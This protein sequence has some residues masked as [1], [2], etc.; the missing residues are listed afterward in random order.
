MDVRKRLILQFILQLVFVGAVLIGLMVGMI[1]YLADQMTEMEM[2]REFAK[3]GLPK[4]VESMEMKEGTFQFDENL[5]DRVKQS[6]GWLQTLDEEGQV[7][8]SHFT[9]ANVPDRYNPGELVDYWMGKKP[10]P[11]SLYIWIQVKGGTTYTLLY[12]VKPEGGELVQ[13]LTEQAAFSDGKILIPDDMEQTLKAKHG[14]VQVLDEQGDEVASLYKPSEALTHYTLKD[15]IFGSFSTFSDSYR[16]WSNYEEKTG[17]TWVVGLPVFEEE[18]TVQPPFVFGSEGQLLLFGFALFLAAV[19]L[20]FGVLSFWYGHR[21][22]TPILHMIRWLQSLGSGVYEEPLD[23]QG[24]PRSRRPSGKLKRRYRLY[25]DVVQMLNGLTETLKRNNEIRTNLEKSREEWI[26]GVSH[27]LKTPL[28]SI[29]GYAHMLESE[30]YDWSVA[31]IREFAGVIKD[32]ADYMDELIADLSMTYRLKNGALPLKMEQTEMNEF[33]RGT[34]ISFQNDP[35]FRQANICFRDAGKPIDYRVDVHWFR[36][37]LDNLLANA[38]LHNPAGTQVEVSLNAVAKSG[39]TITVSD[40][41]EGMDEDEIKNLFERYYRGTNTE[42]AS[43][44]TGLGLA[45]AK[46]LVHEHGGTIE[47]ES[48]PGAGVTIR[49]RF[50]MKVAKDG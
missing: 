20:L 32:K 31:E 7:I 39:F 40:N 25:T 23:H 41:G 11:Y 19:L 16:L 14:W 22:G 45:I 35:G 6:G 9:P 1:Y 21:F 34:V 18:G 17:L 42:G 12:G 29:K 2:R 3:A 13:S 15:L 27:D 10:F 43:R 5:L 8:T 26:A 44:G 36:R 37:I 46:H 30:Q 4:L 33:I 38:L 50:G 49:M 48:G 28:S 24:L 47:A